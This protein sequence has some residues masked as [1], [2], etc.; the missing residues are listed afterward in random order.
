MAPEPHT[1]E[2]NRQFLEQIEPHLTDE[3]RL[4]MLTRGSTLK[5]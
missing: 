2:E 3:N 4:R 5:A 1:I